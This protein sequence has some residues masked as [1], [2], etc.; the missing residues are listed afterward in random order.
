M[1][2]FRH[3]PYT[4]ADGPLNMAADEVLLMTAAYEGIVS[5][6]FYGWSRATVSLG[7][8]Q[9]AADRFIHS[10]L[11]ALPWVRRPSGGRTLVHHHEVTY[12]L[13]LPRDSTRAWLSRLHC[14]V[15]LPALNALGLEGK[16]EVVRGETRSHGEVLCL[17]Q[18][19][20]GDLLC[21]GS[22]IA[23]SAQRKHHRALLQHGAILLR[24]SEHTP[25][26]PG[27]KELTGVELAVAAVGKAVLSAFE[28]ETGWRQQ[29]G[30]WMKEEKELLQGLVKNKYGTTDW[31]EKR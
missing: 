2:T 20:P 13:A 26:L 15:V 31:N 3:F 18:W 8:F 22:K 10:R 16:I 6:R 14:Q 23:G 25:E 21:S 29:Q 17:Q 12:A 7:Y 30:D 9:P 1:K 27:I 11:A 19:T 5:L 28:R 24:Q 4:E